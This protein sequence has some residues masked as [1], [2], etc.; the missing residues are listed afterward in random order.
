[1]SHAPA[2]ID[3]RKAWLARRKELLTASECAAVLGQDPRRGPLAVYAEK[4]GDV[5]VEETPWMRWGRRVEGAIAEGYAEET[6]RPVTDLGA[7]EIQVHPALP[8][9]GATLDRQTAGSEKTPA[10]IDHGPFYGAPL[11]A[12]AVAGH[13]AAE[14]REDPPL[15]YQ[16][17]L[18]VQIA[19]TS[20]T[21]GSLVALIGGL[22]LAW[23]DLLRNDRFLAA[24]LPKLEEFWLRVQRRDPPEADALPGT[25]IAIK[26]LWSEDDGETVALGHEALEL[27][28][29]WE[30]ARL[31]TTEAEE[32]Q[33]DLENKL[34]LR[35]QG[36]TFGALPDGTFVTLKT[37]SR[38]GYT[39][40]V[41]PTT[42]RTLRRFRPR[43][44]RR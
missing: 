29:G 13:K 11:E 2:I 20:A 5:E 15:E 18:Q 33:Q 10:P 9:L 16:I 17:Q 23:R 27:V 19:C 4:V 21:W 26:R 44:R 12:K 6:G 28:D 31:R 7:H 40:V 39:A 34:R 37:T 1:M 24:A 38:K 25:T 35:L 36:A 42:Y 8:W 3:A 43:I 41:E 30:A 14:W 32:R 22:S